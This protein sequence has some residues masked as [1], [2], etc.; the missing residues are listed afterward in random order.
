MG[1]ELIDIEEGKS[2][3]TEVS[4]HVEAVLRA[5]ITSGENRLVVVTNRRIGTTAKGL[6]TNCCEFFYWFGAVTLL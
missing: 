1:Y 6:V 4:W 5:I 2:T 3:V